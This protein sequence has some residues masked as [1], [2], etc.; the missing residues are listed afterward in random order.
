M[1][2]RS[3]LLA[4]VLVA[5][6]VIGSVAV[7]AYDS[8]RDDRIAEGVTVGGVDVG[9][10]ST[11]EARRVVRPQVERP[12]EKPV[13]V[14]Y[15]GRR[16]VLSPRAARLHADVGG[17]V[18][19]ALRRSRDGTIVGRVLR[20]LTGSAEDVDVPTRLSYSQAAVSGLVRRVARSLNRSARN[21][22]VVQFVPSLQWIRSREGVAVQRAELS[23]RVEAAL[24][25]PRARSVAV[26]VKVSRPRVTQN[27]LSAR[28][29]LLL[30]VDRSSFQ[31]RVYRR[32]RMTRAYTVAVGQQGF[33]TPPGIYRIQNKAV[34]P[35][36]Q[37]P[38]RA[39][40]GRLAGRLIPPGPE[41]PIKARWLGIYDGA[42]IH[43]TDAVSSLGTRASHG[44]V[45]MAIPDV[46]G[47]YPQVPVGTPIYIGG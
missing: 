8:A 44:C 25:S 41:N 9:G 19:E 38:N 10:M 23:R 18:D 45:R 39:W 1:R 13:T 29:P 22:R 27:A 5:S 31:L 37:V 24:H 3:F 33:D 32:L 26:P 2:H 4:S 7:Y 15:R 20:D 17:M 40:A 34:N 6:L 12:L 14:G 36:W 16:F 47:L 42:G 28:Y 21:A 43:G 30:V 35:P 11:A 46:V